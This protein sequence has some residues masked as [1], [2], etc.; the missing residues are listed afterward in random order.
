MKQKTKSEID[1]TRCNLYGPDGFPDMVDI[2]DK[3]NAF[4][5]VIA[6]RA[7]GK[8]VSGV[9]ALDTIK[10]RDSLEDPFCFFMRRTGSIMDELM[11]PLLNPFNDANKCVGTSLFPDKLGKTSYA[12][13]DLPN[14]DGTKSPSI[15]AAGKK[16]AM[17]G[18]PLSTIA[19]IRGFSTPSIKFILYDE[20]VPE[21]SQRNT[22]KDEGDALDNAYETINRNRELNGEPAVKFIALANN[23]NIFKSEIAY[24]WGL[25]EAINYMETHNVEQYHDDDACLSVIFLK[26]SPI[27]EAK[28]ETALYKRNRKLNNNGSESFTDMAISNTSRF[29]ASNIRKCVLTEY[30]PLFR[31]GSLFVYRHKSRDEYFATFKKTGTFK[32]EYEFTPKDEIA[33]MERFAYLRIVYIANK[34]VFFENAIANVVFEKIFDIK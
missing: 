5:A 22:I 32:H 17:I 18:A 12:I 26:R 29:D 8:T 27:S 2:I 19:N 11:N 15:A 13:Y 33:I 9:G 7:V 10:K 1:T 16:P 28:K 14:Y 21:K 20:A 31:V 6:A 4:C 23:N 24:R 30:K 25:I 34:S 3:S